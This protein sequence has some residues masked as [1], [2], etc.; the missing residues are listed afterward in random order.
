MIAFFSEVPSGKRNWAH[1]RTDNILL[2]VLRV[3][4]VLSN[5]GLSHLDRWNKRNIRHKR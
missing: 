5:T 4:I 1:S 2:M 3:D